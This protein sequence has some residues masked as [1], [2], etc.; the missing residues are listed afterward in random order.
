MCEPLTPDEMLERAEA[1]AYQIIA[2]PSEDR[3][4]ALADVDS[5]NRVMSIM[6]RHKLKEIA[7][8]A[9]E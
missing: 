2:L 1:I 4:E 7:G 8:E 3:D 9:N 6:V 5:K